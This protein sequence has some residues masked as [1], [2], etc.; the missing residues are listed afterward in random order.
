MTALSRIN[1]GT[2]TGPCKTP[3][4]NCVK[5]RALFRGIH[6]QI[7]KPGPAHGTPEGPPDGPASQHVARSVGPM[8][9]RLSPSRAVSS[10]DSSLSARATRAAA[11]SLAAVALFLFAGPAVAETCQAADAIRLVLM[12][13]H[14]EE[15]FASWTERD[16]L[17]RVTVVELW[18]NLNE[19]GMTLL[20]IAPTGRAC[21]VGTGNNFGVSRSVAP[22]QGEPM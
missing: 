8:T 17:H 14:G 11:A 2:L 1:V 12:L 9:G 4:R 18:G 20:R 15:R 6:D 5:V 22:P 7:T 3:D 10:R 16:A 13:K 21:V 19:G